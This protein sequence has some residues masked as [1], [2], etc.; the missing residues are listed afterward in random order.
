MFYGEEWI[1]K[2]NAKWTLKNCDTPLGCLVWSGKGSLNEIDVKAMD[3][4][5]ITPNANLEFYARNGDLC[6]YVFFPIPNE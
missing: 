4:F 2:N 1:I 3:E 5:L 6:I